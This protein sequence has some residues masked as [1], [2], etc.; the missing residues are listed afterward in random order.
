M[1]RVIDP[2]RFSCQPLDLLLGNAP[3]THTKVSACSVLAA[4]AKHKF[5]RSKT[6]ANLGYEQGMQTQ[7][8]HSVQ[9]LSQD[10]SSSICCDNA[11]RIRCVHVLHCTGATGERV[12]LLIRMCSFVFVWCA[13]VCAFSPVRCTQSLLEDSLRRSNAFHPFIK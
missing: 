1:A 7:Q 9:M 6:C 2:N 3:A 10:L 5:G 12:F 4:V 13:S 8:L 11:H